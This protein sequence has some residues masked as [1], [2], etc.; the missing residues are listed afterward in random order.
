[1]AESDPIVIG[2]EDTQGEHETRESIRQ[3]FF[4]FVPLFQDAFVKVQHNQREGLEALVPF[5]TEMEGRLSAI[6][7]QA[8]VSEGGCYPLTVVG[9]CKCLHPGRWLDETFISCYAKLLM[10]KFP[11]MAIISGLF[12]Q[13]LFRHEHCRGELPEEAESRESWD[14]VLLVIIR[15]GHFS[16]VH[17]QATRS[18]L[19]YYDSMFTLPED[20]KSL[21]PEW[22]TLYGRSKCQFESWPRHAEDWIWHV[23]Q[24]PRQANSDDCG[25]FCCVFMRMALGAPSLLSSATETVNFANMLPIRRL[26]CLEVACGTLLL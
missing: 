25:V 20:L 4:E 9:F 16:L 15:D 21:L 8:I 26:L 2:D 13:M 23:V 14:N 1:M 7:Q 12:V 19:H 3:K 22:L 5:F 17:I 18:T 24:V 10:S 6:D 11:A